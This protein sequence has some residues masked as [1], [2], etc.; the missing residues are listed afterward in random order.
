MSNEGTYIDCNKA[1][2]DARS[3]SDKQRLMQDMVSTLQWGSKN[4]FSDN[5]SSQQFEALTSVRT[6]EAFIHFMHGNSEKKR[7]V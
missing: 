4:L 6:Q 3:P 2:R 1:R 5:R 7:S